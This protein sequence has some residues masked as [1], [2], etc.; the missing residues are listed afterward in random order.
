MLR[1]EIKSLIQEAGFKGDNLDEIIDTAYKELF[2]DDKY[3]L[4]LTYYKVLGLRGSILLWILVDHVMALI[5]I[6]CR[7]WWWW[8]RSIGRY[9]GGCGDYDWKIVVLHQVH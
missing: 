4:L 9:W 6:D 2:N 8:E 1:E 3:I 7:E 5:G